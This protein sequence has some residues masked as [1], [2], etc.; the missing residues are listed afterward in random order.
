MYLLKAFVIGS[1]V[2]LAVM[3]TLSVAINGVVNM[4]A[5]AAFG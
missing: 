4:I 3:W 1:G 5:V 2:Y